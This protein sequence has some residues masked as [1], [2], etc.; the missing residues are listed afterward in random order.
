M[1]TAGH[2]PV[3]NTCRAATSASVADH[4]QR[5][6]HGPGY[7]HGLAAVQRTDHCGLTGLPAVEVL[8][9]PA[10]LFPNL[11]QR[12]AKPN[13]ATCRGVR[14]AE[15]CLSTRLPRPDSGGRH[16]Q[17]DADLR[18]RGEPVPHLRQ[19]LARG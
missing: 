5:L 16:G 13:G 6:P 4:A 18:R 10:G 2:R 8:Y 3:T 1:P 14:L 9:P 11:A 17:H 12:L 15:R 7:R 19:H